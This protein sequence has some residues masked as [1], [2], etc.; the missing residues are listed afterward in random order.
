[1][2]H[3]P[4]IQS[5]TVLEKDAAGQHD[6]IVVQQHEAPS[7]ADGGVAYDP[8]KEKDAEVARTMMNWLRKHY[9]G[10]FWNAV[11]DLRHGIVKFNITILMG[12]NNWWLINLRTHPDIIA[13]LARGAGEILERYR[14]T[15]GRFILD[16]FLEARAKHSALLV[17]NRKV[18]T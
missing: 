1:M 5:H 6:M 18:P 11:A 7:T 10:H 17:P 12:V 4:V 14:Q 2:P 8:F 13:E 9:P 15:R 3:D 16:E